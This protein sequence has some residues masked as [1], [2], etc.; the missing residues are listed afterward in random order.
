MSSQGS[1]RT[2]AMP[3][4]DHDRWLG[5]YANESSFL[6]SRVG[7]DPHLEIRLAK[8]AKDFDSYLQ[9]EE[10]AYSYKPIDC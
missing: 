1:F 6:K 9:E 3:P 8:R 4:R 10:N 7:V 5:R 2:N